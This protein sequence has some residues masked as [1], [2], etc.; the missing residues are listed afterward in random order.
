MIGLTESPVLAPGLGYDRAAMSYDDWPW[1]LFWDQNEKPIVESL[2]R[3]MPA[4]SV[5]A[6][7]G[8]G[9]GRYFLVLRA[10]GVRNVVGVDLSSGML[11]VAKK[12]AGT[13][14][15]VRAD[16]RS[17]PIASGRVDLAIAARSLC[18][19]PEIEDEFRETGRILRR[20]GSLIVT[21]LDADHAFER[22]RLPTAS[23]EVLIATWKRQASELV[24]SAERAGLR[25]T[26]LI[27]VRSTD[28]RWLPPPPALPSIDRAGGR[29]IFVVVMFSKR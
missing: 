27:R 5:A 26:Q 14:G 15:L 7:L 6:D 16:V 11:T 20:G 1:Q 2:I 9:T 4:P 25:A 18:H 17:L 23:G 28:C 19:L 3:K 12:R 10:L 13:S 24:A 29:A 8:V 22:T 21:E